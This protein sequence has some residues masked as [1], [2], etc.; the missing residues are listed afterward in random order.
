[1]DNVYNIAAGEPPAS[2]DQIV[3]AKVID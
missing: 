2:P 1:M 3:S